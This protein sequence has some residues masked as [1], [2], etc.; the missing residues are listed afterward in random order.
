MKPSKEYLDSIA[1]K[2]DMFNQINGVN[3][4][5][6]PYLKDDFNP[7]DHMGQAAI[8]YLNRKK[9]EIPPPE[10]PLFRNHNNH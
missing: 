1:R 8:N 10:D 5:Q 4:T 3:P 9:N 2:L 7:M 6:S